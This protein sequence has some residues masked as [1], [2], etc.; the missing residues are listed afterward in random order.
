MRLE[1]YLVPIW[2]FKILHSG[3]SIIVLVVKMGVCAVVGFVVFGCRE[4]QFAA[5]MIRCGNK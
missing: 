3:S 2:I 4:T 5:R 1:N